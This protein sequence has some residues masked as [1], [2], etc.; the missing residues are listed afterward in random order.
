MHWVG[1][2]RRESTL[3]GITDNLW[4]RPPALLYCISNESVGW[5]PRARDLLSDRR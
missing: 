3:E 5:F 2:E 1:G 4:L